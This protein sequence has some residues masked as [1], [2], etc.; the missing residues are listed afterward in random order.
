MTRRTFLAGLAAGKLY[1][2][3]VGSAKPYVHP[4]YFPDGR[5][6]TLDGPKDHIHHRGL[7]LGWN[8]VNGFDFW[9]ET[10]PAPHGRI[11][12]VRMEKGIALNHWVAGGKVLLEE[13]RKVAAEARPEGTWLTWSSELRAAGDP[14]TLSGEGHPYDGLG[15]RFIHEMDK[16]RCL[17]SRGTTEIEKANGEP[18]G[19]C[20][21]FHPSIGGVAI[22]DHRSNPR[23]PSPFFVMNQF[24][25]LSAAPTF[26]EPLRVERGRP[27]HFRWGVLAYL[28]APDAKTLDRVFS[29]FVAE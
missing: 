6:A 14:V 17:N 11:E 5:E 20:T 18:A 4:L 9:G 23:H 22:F 24:G 28:G 13:W 2:S 15:I 27:L 1:D 21:Y 16:G 12:Q 26:R 7:M 8:N 19:W 25:Y 3:R 29:R 10:N